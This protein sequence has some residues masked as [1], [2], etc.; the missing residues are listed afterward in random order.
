MAA[1]I[2]GR[3]LEEPRVR[4]RGGFRMLE[5]RES[6]EDLCENVFSWIVR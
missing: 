5:E 4:A 1:E 6:R 2:V 3:R